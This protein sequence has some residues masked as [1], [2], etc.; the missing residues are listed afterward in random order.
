MAE[1]KKS[2][3]GVW[4]TRIRY[5]D[6]TTNEW[7]SKRFSGATKKEVRDQ[8]AE[9]VTSIASGRIIKDVLLVD[10]YKTWRDTYKKGNVSTSR[11]NKIELVGRYLEEFFGKKQ[12]L[13]GVTKLNYQKFINW[14]VKKGWAQETIDNRHSIA[15]SMF[16]E[17]YEAGLINI[18]PTR[19]ISF[20]G[21]KPVH[22]CVKTLSVEETKKLKH[23]LL[24]TELANVNTFVLLQLLTG[25]RYQEI[26]ALTWK[27]IDFKN[28]TIDINKAYEYAGGF[29]GF[30]EPKSPAGYRTVDVDKDGLEV[31]RRHKIE[32]SKLLLAKKL[33]NP[34]NLLFPNNCSGWPISNSFVNRNLILLCK[35]VDVPRSS[36]HTLRHA[37]TDFLILSGAD[38]LYV[39]DQLGHEDYNTTLKHY[40]SLSKEI[41]DKSRIA[42]KELEKNVL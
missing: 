33:R 15:R 16:L 27:D 25:C 23:Y 36:S 11:Y 22:P 3:N 12:T 4:G 14:M 41:R 31:V 28:N 38:P 30:K 10:Y 5:K 29:K 35:A 20:K 40:A 8:E 37:R 32:Q 2:K 24:N 21:T 26:A 19:N 17:A 9:F 6:P 34:F 7:K 42:V 1:I 18:N 13:K 39:K